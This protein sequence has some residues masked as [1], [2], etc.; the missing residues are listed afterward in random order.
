MKRDLIRLP[1]HVELFFE[2][3]TSA[4]K[5]HVLEENMQKPTSNMRR[6]T[7][8]DICITLEAKE[9]ELCVLLTAGQTPVREIVLIWSD[10]MRTAGEILPDSWE[11]SNG[12]LEWQ[13]AEALKSSSEKVVMPWY[14]IDD[15]TFECRGYGVKVRPNAMCW[16]EL[17]GN[18]LLLHLDV[19]SGAQGVVLN[20]RQLKV[21]SV[22][23]QAYQKDAFSA[24]QSFCHAMCTDSIYD[25][26]PIYGSNNW[27]YAYGK[28]SRDAMLRDAEY[29]AKMTQG[30]K[31][32]PFMVVDDGWEIAYNPS[33]NGGPWDKGNQD[34][35]DMKQLAADMK[36]FD[37]RP[38][39]WFRP[40]ANTALPEELQSMRDSTVLDVSRPEVLEYVAECMQ[41]FSD[42]GFELVKH[43]F[44]TFD[45]FGRWSFDLGSELTDDGWH[46]WDTSKT[47]AEIIITFYETIYR[48]AGNMIVLGCNC[49]GHLGAGLMH[50]NRT[51]SDTSGVDWDRT[52]DMGVNTLAFR[53]PQHGAF[54]AADADC[55]GI[56][57]K[58]PWDKN[59]QW[60]RLLAESGTPFFVSV[61]PGTLDSEQEA[62]LKAAYQ[63]ASV[64]RPV[65]IPL[66]WKQTR[67]PNQWKTV[68]GLV[69]FEW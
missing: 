53:T 57:D 22:L 49:V 3:G 6:Y 61:K 4:V 43:D 36:K 10:E 35:G 46:F 15:R 42:W 32:R 24:D 9:E 1:D 21:A 44:S 47:T 69:S 14:F 19:R 58:I 55:V 27:Y 63:K 11:R 56:T 33:Y 66:D 30:I 8:H 48:S 45:I 51:G 2:D 31:N 23:M 37:I 38:G 5:K 65:A 40:L 52:R 41:R 25:G 50:A 29:L 17:Q 12:D 13:N 26:T 67:L 34:Y 68:D 60:M 54:Y 16:W 18:D 39:L 64:Q 59:R 62:E 7:A 28:S 20:G